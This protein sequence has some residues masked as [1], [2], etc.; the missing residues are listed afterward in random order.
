MNKRRLGG[1]LDV[2]VMGY[3][4]MGLSFGYGPAAETSAAVSLI[5]HAV[6]LGVTLFDTA[7]VH[8]PFANED[9][10]G[11][12]LSPVRDRVVIA[13]KFGFDIDS[14]NGLTTDDLREIEEAVAKIEIQGA[15]YPESAQR[16]IDR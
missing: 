13:T 4:C 10:V 8:G 12:A 16:M 11:E 3:G 6:D 5:R 9:V 1:S 15:R 7:E 14:E 2:S